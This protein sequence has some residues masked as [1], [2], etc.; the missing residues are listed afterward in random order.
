MPSPAERPRVLN[1]PP[2]QPTALGLIALSALSRSGFMP[3]NMALVGA[4]SLFAGARLPLR[5]ALA[6]PMVSMLVS[7][8]V[9]DS[10]NGRA[11]FTFE[12]LT[13]YASYLAIVALGRLMRKDS[14]L[15]K[16]GALGLAGSIIFFA[17]S[18]FGYWVSA[19]D[20]PHTPEGLWLSY[21]AAVPFWRNTL[22]SDVIGS[23]AIFGLDALARRAGLYGVEPTAVADASPAI[24][25]AD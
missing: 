25:R 16:A 8:L 20:V 14:N 24:A 4:T 9:I 2:T 15:L 21:L 1:G 10:S 6:V 11:A 7:D 5:W 22:L 17:A 3:W 23:T 18:N 19:P 12:R 13:I